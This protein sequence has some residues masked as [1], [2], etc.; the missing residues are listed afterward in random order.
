MSKV[1]R[2]RRKTR[3]LNREGEQQEDEAPAPDR[4]SYTVVVDG[5]ETQSSQHNHLAGLIAEEWLDMTMLFTRASCILPKRLKLEV[6]DVQKHL[7]SS[8]LQYQL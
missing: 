2:A 1:G 8:E 4:L 6:E 5:A 3:I 7:L